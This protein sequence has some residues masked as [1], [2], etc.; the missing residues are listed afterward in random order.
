MRQF[1]DKLSD[2]ITNYIGSWYFI[3][4]FFGLLLGW[5]GLNTWIVSWD[6]YPYTFLNLV[7]STFAAIQGSIIMMSQKRQESKDR[8]RNIEI[9]KLVR[10]CES[11]VQQVR[12]DR[13]THLEKPVADR[14]THL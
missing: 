12:A 6:V 7:L 13:D 14:D 11:Y 1:F 3:F 10:N 9:Y 8:E 5:I 4:S 2:G